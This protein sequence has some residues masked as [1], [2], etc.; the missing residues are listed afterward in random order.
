MQKNSAIV[1]VKELRQNLDNYISQIK[2]GKSLTIGKRSQPVLK[3]SPIDNEEM[4]EEII[5]FTKMKNGGVKI[6]EILSR[7]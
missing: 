4:W 6:E 1:G 3:I 2:K 5:D 7:I